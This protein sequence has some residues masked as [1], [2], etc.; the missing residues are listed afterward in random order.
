MHLRLD[1][2]ALFTA[3]TMIFAAIALAKPFDA[4]FTVTKVSGNVTI[5]AP[6]AAIGDAK[7]G[8]A[9]PYGSKIKT[10]RRSS[11]VLTLSDGNSV[12]IS[13]KT[14]VIV[15]EESKTFKRILLETGVVDLLMDNMDKGSKVDV[16]MAA[17]ICGI[18]GTHVH[19][20]A[21]EEKKVDAAQISITQGE[22]YIKGAYF[23]IP[24]FKG[25]VV[26]SS[27]KDERYTRIRNLKG[28]HN[29]FILHPENAREIKFSEG[30]LAKIYVRISKDKKR[31]EI[32]VLVYDS[33]A[34]NAKVKETITF[35]I[36][37]STTKPP[38]HGP[39]GSHEDFE[40]GEEETSTSSS[41]TPPTTPP[42]KN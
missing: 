40:L 21:S 20:E 5:Q 24:K 38:T 25:N 37:R 35:S 22:G 30:N 15:N 17:A 32:T 23:E 12:R 29:L 6:D 1:K 19:A 31:L 42:G 8:K 11:A 33:D 10:A 26:I 28:E 14:S 27:T 34:P 36:V 4:D 16:E 18:V 39:S 9:Y 41:S 2:V 13:A 7:V 3:S